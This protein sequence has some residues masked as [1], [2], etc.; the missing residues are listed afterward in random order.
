MKFLSLTIPNGLL[1][2]SVG[3]TTLLRFILY[4]LGYSI[5]ST[6]GINFSKFE[7]ELKVLTDKN[8][9]LKICRRGDSIFLESN[10]L[11][12]QF[13]LPFDLNDLHKIVFG[14]NNTEVLDN[15]LGVYYVDQE[16]GWTGLNR[17]ICIGNIHFNI[18]ELVRGLANQS[19]DGLAEKL[20]AV[21]REIQK[22]K[23]MLNI[24]EYKKEINELGENIAYDTPEEEVENEL[25][26]LYA[27]R[28]PV[29]DELKR[30]ES[31]IKKNTSFKK[32]ISN[33]KISVQSPT[34]G[35][36]VPVN[37]ETIVALRETEELIT[38][39][40][41]FVVNLL[42]TIDK[43]IKT[44]EHK[45]NREQT[46]ISFKT[47][48]EEF[49]QSV[50]KMDI[51]ALTVQ[52]TISNLVSTKKAL[53]EQITSSVKQN[54]ALITALHNTISLYAQELG[55]DEKYV[56]ANNDYIFTSILKD[57]SGAI[58]HKIVF[59]FR[60]G[61]IK[62]VFDYTGTRL[63]IILDS[64]SGREIEKENVDSMIKILVRDFS[65]YQIIIASIHDY[66]FPKKSII[67]I[68][69]QLLPQ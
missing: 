54:T 27:E 28:K 64:P 1:G 20:T 66:D 22:Y 10:G 63:P 68:N 42:T 57:L 8:E 41:K 67:E 35:E 59:A 51:D 21:K 37:E 36:I 4:T 49:D 17:Y 23:H 62:A 53:D 45:R 25:E 34:S 30:L 55:L 13:S 31:V 33:F 26:V 48:L 50:L 6:R 39:R 5:P 44:L 46:L 60:L 38:A 69:E 47:T 2:D 58:F 29:A 24:A 15:L 11:N 61:Y 43:K 14:I 3:K 52:R 9:T 56:R 7:P 16:K 12:A 32:H 18:E 19:A 65:E 40:R